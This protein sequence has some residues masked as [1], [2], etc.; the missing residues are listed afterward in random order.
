MSAHSHHSHIT[1]PCSRPHTCTYIYTHTLYATHTYTKLCT[2]SPFTPSHI[3][4][5]S[6]LQCLD[7]VEASHLFFRTE[8]GQVR[9]RCAVSYFVIVLVYLRCRGFYSYTA[10][11]A[12]SYLIYQL[13]WV[14]S[15]HMSLILLFSLQLS[16]AQF[17]FFFPP[18]APCTSSSLAAALWLYPSCYSLVLAQV[19]MCVCVSLFLCVCENLQPEPDLPQLHCPMGGL[20]KWAR[21]K[22][23]LREMES[24]NHGG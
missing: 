21:Q 5:C 10:P 8:S 13:I 15:G 9:A 2:S 4:C 7:F 22:G 12:D 14:S 6:W 3:C 24:Y 1:H 17:N 11:P 16:W 20:S 18:S 23:W 19:C